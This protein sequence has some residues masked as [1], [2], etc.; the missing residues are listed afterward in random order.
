MRET[1]GHWP[2]AKSDDRA[3][4]PVYSMRNIGNRGLR[5]A[6]RISSLAIDEI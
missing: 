6:T 3:P 1:P 5:A 2:R 4:F